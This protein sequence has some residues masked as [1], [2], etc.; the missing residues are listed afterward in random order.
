[1]SRRYHIKTVADFLEIP[2]D[3]RAECLADFQHWLAVMD[4]HKKVE[5]LLDQLA[6]TRGAFSARHDSFTWFD[7][8]KRGV[9]GVEFN[10]EDE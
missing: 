2:K 7:D 1:M 9:S 3:K 8:G 10:A 5:G 6:D 4:N